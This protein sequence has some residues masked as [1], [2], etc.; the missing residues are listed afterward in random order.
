[1]TSTFTTYKVTD[2]DL[3][4]STVLRR[5]PKVQLASVL[6]LVKILLISDLMSLRLL[7]R[8]FCCSLVLLFYISQDG[9][10]CLRFCILLD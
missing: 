3:S 10:H 2:C 5:L 6:S 9:F 4:I 8:A 7:A 1:M